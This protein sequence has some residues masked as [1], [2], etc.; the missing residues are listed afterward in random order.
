MV[1]DPF[2]GSVSSDGSSSYKT[3]ID[4]ND[5]GKVDENDMFHGSSSL[6]GDSGGAG[7]GNT[8]GL[9]IVGLGFGKGETSGSILIVQEQRTKNG[10]GNGSGS[11]SGT[12]DEIESTRSCAIDSEGVRVCMPPLP[13]GAPPTTHSW[14]ELRHDD[15][16]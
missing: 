10:S 14:M 7:G 13:E 9:P 16:Q 3:N 8:G 15:K 11:G 4:V 5:D 2:T 1:I 6:G 12:N